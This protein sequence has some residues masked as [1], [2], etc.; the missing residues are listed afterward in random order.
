L[1][2]PLHRRAIEHIERLVKQTTKGTRRGQD[3]TEA[4]KLLLTAAQLI[5]L[6]TI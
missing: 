2:P 1:L 5:C 4:D 3:A 6:A